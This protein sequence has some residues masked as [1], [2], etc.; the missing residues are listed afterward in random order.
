MQGVT[1]G[2]GPSPCST[3]WPGWRVT[4][5]H[6][7]DLRCWHQ[8]KDI[9]HREVAVSA[10]NWSQKASSVA[11]TGCGGTK[12]Q[13][14]MISCQQ[15]HGIPNSVTEARK[16][17]PSSTPAGA[18]ESSPWRHPSVAMSPGWHRQAGTLDTDDQGSAGTEFSRQSPTQS[19]RRLV[20]PSN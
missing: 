10:Q 16:A 4:P 1:A 6:C 5:P 19:L 2:A 14:C 7:P 12:C 9:L 13:S 3:E 15:V 18:Q 17:S 8:R 11:S 20:T